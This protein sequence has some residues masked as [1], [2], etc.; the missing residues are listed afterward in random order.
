MR[1]A[2]RVLRI[3]EGEERVVALVMALMFVATAAITVGES[4]VE[5]LFFARVGAGALPSMYLLQGGVT[6]AAMLVLTDTFGRLGPRRAYL[7]APVALGLFVF[8]ER[9][10]LVADSGWTYRLL[11]ITVALGTLVQ[12]IFLWGTAGAVVDVRQAK[13]LFPIFGA[14]GIL[15]SVVGGLATR[16][17]AAAVGTTNL[18]LVWAAGLGGAFLLARLL[19]GP[20]PA[21]VPR[22]PRRDVHGVQALRAEVAFVC[23][24]RL[25][26]LMTVAS[27]LFSVLFYVLYLPYARAAAERFPNVEQLAGFFGL[28]WAAGTAAAFVVSL[29]ATNRLF[30]WFGVAAMVVVLPFIYATAFAVLLVG[31]G[32]V[33]LVGL[34]FVTGVWLQAV[35]Q[36]GWEALT[37]V[38]QERRRDQTRAFLNGGPMQ[39]GTVLA[40]V[41]ALI[42]QGLTLRWLA[43]IGLVSAAV[44][45]LITVG[46]RRSYTGAL[47]DALD[48]GRPNV[49]AAAAVH[50]AAVRVA[51]D[52]DSVRVLA[53]RL[54]SPDVR[55]RRLAYQLL[56]DL[57]TAARPPALAVGLED[58]DPIVR[59][60]A[61]RA[62]DV[63]TA[64]GPAAI[65]S[66]IQDPDVRVSAAAAARCLQLNDEPRAA[67][68]LSHL[69]ADPDDRTRRAAVAQLGLAPDAWVARLASAALEDPAPTVRAAA[70]DR[71]ARAAPHHALAAA[72]KGLHDPDPGVRIVAGRA[73]GCASGRRI[74]DVLA[75]LE[76]DMTTDA[77]IEA[78]RCVELDGDRDRVRAFVHASAAQ[79]TR[80]RQVAEAI[81]ASDVATALLHD[82]ILER[83]RRVARAGLWA[84]ATLAT[85]RTEMQTA[86]E[87]LDGEPALVANALEALDTAGDPRLVRPLLELWEHPSRSRHEEDWLSLALRDHDGF[88][89][90]CAELVRVRSAG[91]PMAE[92]LTS[93]S[94]VERVLLLREVPLLADL[95]PTDLERVA[96]LVEEAGYIDG[97]TIAAEGELGED[98]HIVVDGTVRV[99]QGV[100]RSER[101][102]A[103]RTAGDVVGEMSIITREPRV[104]SLVASDAVR[105]IRLGHREFVSILRERPAVALAVMRVLA[106]RVSERSGAER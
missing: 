48:D 30:G 15:G 2:S 89:R 24:S 104:A 11:W 14:G 20:P 77:G 97:E 37:N 21:R 70:L 75:A 12:A 10:V 39:I 22:R 71:F 35:A 73:L 31:S 3:H 62:L 95:A 47:I 8:A 6:F 59:L 81:A 27:V 61:V 101:E 85:R 18:L 68:Q 32:F 17:L 74:D 83:G 67:S 7:V 16:P 90:Q 4:G 43:A 92:P 26:T 29:S 41:L 33:L 25:L 45:I 38:V 54:R 40:G 91:G 79:A 78:S 64:P 69:L 42:G 84:A 102:L 53:G 55:V 52:A 65:L 86:I 5:A 9:F 44:S 106:H 23:R 57:P 98:L 66:M 87:H 60:A 56:A 28:F 63:G 36:P 96:E 99:V 76:D 82:A 50:R 13:R 105:T 103:R 1:V 93:L 46:I 58:A 72:R 94:I 19:L 80:D 51:S 100:G 49:F 88:I 34:R